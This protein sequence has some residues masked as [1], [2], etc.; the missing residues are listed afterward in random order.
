[1]LRRGK[2]TEK[3]VKS[4]RINSVAR[5]AMGVTAGKWTA[6]ASGNVFCDD[7]MF[8]AATPGC[9]DWQAKANGETIANLLNERAEIIYALEKVPEL[10]DALRMANTTNRRLRSELEAAQPTALA[11]AA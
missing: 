3:P 10:L 11:V 4:E 6:D 1:M 9:P 7:Q 2:K 5:V 8:L